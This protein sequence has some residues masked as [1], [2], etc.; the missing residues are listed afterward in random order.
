MGC[1][2]RELSASR[3]RCFPEAWLGRDNGCGSGAVFVMSWWHGRVSVEALLSLA[4]NQ[5][6]RGLPGNVGEARNNLSGN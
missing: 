4:V 3:S 6:A 1:A 5:D 2:G